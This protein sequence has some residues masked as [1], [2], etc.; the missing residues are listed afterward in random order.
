MD[1][2]NDETN[3]DNTTDGAN[4]GNTNNISGN[5][6]FCINNTGSINLNPP[7]SSFN[8]FTQLI[9][10]DVKNIIQRESVGKYIRK[11]SIFAGV[12]LA[13]AVI[14][15]CLNILQCFGV[16]NTQLL[17]EFLVC[18]LLS[19][20]LFSGLNGKL[21]DNLFRNGS[22]NNFLLYKGN[23]YFLSP[24]GDYVE[25]QSLFARCVYPFCNGQIFLRAAPPREKNRKIIGCCSVDAK[26]HTYSCD[27]NLVVNKCPIDWR[28]L[29][30]NRTQ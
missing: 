27:K 26:N 23:Y 25:E 22:K 24:D 11:R 21:W 20:F 7:N 3:K 1:D 10:T 28:P 18:C 9:K 5:G 30:D 17:P 2:T 14:A 4:L 13:I 29:S 16:N 12:S 6:N 19:V 15:N 8:E